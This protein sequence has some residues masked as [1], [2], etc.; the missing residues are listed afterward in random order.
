MSV[1]LI[2]LLIACGLLFVILEILVIPGVG[3]VG[4]LGGAM[5]IFAVISAYSISATHG[6]IALGGSVVLSVL[7]IFLSIKAKTWEK[8]SLSNVMEGKANVREGIDINIGDTG[9]T[10]SR[11]NPMGKAY[12][13]DNIYEVESIEGY[14]P[15]DSEVTVVQA[16]SSKIKVKTKQ[17]T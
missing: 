2:I 6:H 10:I 8:I 12:F 5:I 15:E 3:V 16:T 1:S 13:N 9:F 11:L 7:S 17:T 4:I 14:I